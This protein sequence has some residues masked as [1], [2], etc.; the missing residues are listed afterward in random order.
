MSIISTIKINNEYYDPGETVELSYVTGSGD[1][2]KTHQIELQRLKHVK[3]GHFIYA[4]LKINPISDYKD[5]KHINLKHRK[6]DFPV[7]NFLYDKN[8][9]NLQTGYQ[10]A[11]HYFGDQ[12]KKLISD[13][14]HKK[15]DSQKLLRLYKN[16]VISKKLKY[17]FYFPFKFF[18]K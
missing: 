9:N 4:E 2:A 7:T 3:K 1:D 10:T 8:E 11:K 12:R 13:V 6:I 16:I 15:L 14:V 18:F 5:I 17:L